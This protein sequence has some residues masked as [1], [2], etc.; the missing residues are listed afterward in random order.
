M[1][2]ILTRMDDRSLLAAWLD[3]RDED[4][5]RLLCERHAPMVRAAAV[6][7]ASPDPDE[8]AQAVFIVLIRRANAVPAEH[9]AGWLVQT[10][11][12]I[13]ANQRRGAA[14]RQRHEQEAARMHNDLRT[15]MPSGEW[16][17]VDALRPLL[18]EGL[19]RLSPARREA[20][21]RYHLAGRTQAEVAAELGCSVDAV[22]TRIHEGLQQLRTFFA[23][24]GHPVGA[25]GILAVFA[26]EAKAFGSAPALS[27][28]C[29]HAALHPAQAGQAAALASTIGT[30]SMTAKAALLTCAL[31][32]LAS[33][34]LGGFA[35]RAT[36]AAA[37]PAPVPATTITDTKPIHPPALSNPRD[38]AA[39]AALVWWRVLD[40]VRN[41]DGG[42]WDESMLRALPWKNQGEELERADRNF[43]VG[44]LPDRVLAYFARGS[45]LSYAD[46]GEDGPEGILAFRPHLPAFEK[47]CRLQCVRARW[48]AFHGRSAA[49][50][51]DLIT[52]LRA[53]RLVVGDQPRIIDWF[54]A[55]SCE[56]QIIASAAAILPRLGAGD[57]GRLAKILDERPETAVLS[58]VVQQERIA[59]LSGFR[60]LR[61]LPASIRQYV[62]GSS[63]C[64]GKLDFR[65]P[66]SPWA[67]VSYNDCTH[68]KEL[69]DATIDRGVAWYHT[70][71][72]SL[73]ASS[74]LPA[75]NR[76]A[77]EDKPGQQSDPVSA[78][79][80]GFAV[81][82]LAVLTKEESHLLRSR[83][84]L[85]LA[86]RLVAEEKS[87]NA[88][89]PITG[90][91]FTIT[92]ERTP[93]GWIIRS[94][95]EAETSAL[96]V[97]IP[98]P[99]P[100]SPQPAIQPPPPP[101]QPKSASPKPLPP[102]PALPAST[103]NPT[104]DF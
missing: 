25:A 15:E 89:D 28:A 72:D 60:Y 74:R 81:P 78:A 104:E 13:A 62:L 24:R 11:R 9:L 76:P 7:A 91:S 29:A 88:R 37:P 55:A 80:L 8:A 16:P 83:A 27:A 19:S 94:P 69:D 84:Q 20:L 47:V 59:W 61:G 38:P 5:V 41:M 33:G 73:I 101:T 93:P 68:P 4:A 87:E 85:R 3:R 40:K 44:D 17:E 42:L 77:Q 52:A 50:C 100:P 23:R 10:A 96:Y 86:L 51:D 31:L 102:K 95:G 57:R 79:W 99:L 46:W 49:A 26:G 103:R 45:R 21:V 75:A 70:R 67:T 1:R 43:Q 34:V 6:R 71:M 2:G 92:G 39:N 48:H 98:P 22:K 64:W 32:A 35:L 82:S 30:L 18:D 66:D 53:V 97:G 54:T 65:Q 90:G 14:R 12:R 58:E 36:D 56:R 63:V